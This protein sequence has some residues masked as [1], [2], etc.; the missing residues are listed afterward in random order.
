MVRESS[1]VRPADG[2][3]SL[4]F[5]QEQVTMMA[6]GWVLKMIGARS[7]RAGLFGY[8]ATRDRNMARIKLEKAR[9]E[10]TKEIIDHLPSREANS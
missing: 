10:A 4:A 2:Y 5:S 3:R 9:Q 7:Q 1:F 8:L 6:W